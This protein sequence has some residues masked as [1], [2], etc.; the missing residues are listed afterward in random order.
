V[1]SE[2]TSLSYYPS[3]DEKYRLYVCQNCQRYLKTIDMRKTLGQV[4]FPVER[5]ITVGLDVAA[6]E[7]GYT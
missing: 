2:P 1:T 4:L 3:E 5:I 7:E 6:Q